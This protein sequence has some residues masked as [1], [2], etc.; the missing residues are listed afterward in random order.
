MDINLLFKEFCNVLHGCGQ[1]LT[2]DSVRYYF[3]GCML[4]QN[5]NFYDY[6]MELPYQVIDAGTSPLRISLTKNH[7]L[8]KHGEQLDQEL[9]LYYDD[10]TDCYCI[11]VKFHR[12]SPNSEY[13]HTTAIGELFNDV[14]RLQTI[15]PSPISDK[16]I[17]KF[18]VYVTDDIM[19]TYLN[20][21]T[22]D[23]KTGGIKNPK[24]NVQFKCF[25]EST[26][27]DNEI[28]I[29]LK[30]SSDNTTDQDAPKSFWEASLKSFADKKSNL[31]AN[32]QV[33][34]KNDFPTGCPSMYNCGKSGKCHIR[35]YEIK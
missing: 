35:M 1:L 21:K 14:R 31:N 3:Y 7:G 12:Y 9:D 8:I 2:E 29:E 28:K 6:T 20:G 15:E 13:A 25:I 10:G 23:E 17:R 30:N 32:L 27:E 16:R 24:A 34:G 5:P 22:L 33:I 26:P 11:E 18:L 4:K 19:W